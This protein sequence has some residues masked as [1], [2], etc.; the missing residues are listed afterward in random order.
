MKRALLALAALVVLAAAT[1]G[2]GLAWL[3]GTEAGLRWAIAAAEAR[4]EGRLRIAEPRGTLSQEVSFG[5]IAYADAGLEVLAE[6]VSGALSLTPLLRGRLGIEPLRIEALRISVQDRG[7]RGQAAP[8]SLPLGVR[9]ARVSVTRIELRAGA[10]RHVLEGLR[11]A[12]AALGPRALSASGEAS[13]RDERFPASVRFALDGTPDELTLALEGKADALPVT[14][15]LRARIASGGARG[16]VAL[17]NAQPGPLDAGKL[18]VVSARAGFSSPDLARATLEDLRV[19]LVGGGALAGAGE[20]S[21]RRARARVDASAVDL[22]ALYSTLRRTALAGT[23]DLEATADAQSVRGRLAQEGMSVRAKVTRRGDTIS[24]EDLY[25]EARGG[26]LAGTG[27]IGLGET[28]RAQARLRLGDFDPAAFGDYPQGSISGRFEL[29][30]R[31]DGAPTLDARWS[32]ERSRLDGRALAST[33]RARFSRERI[34]D[35]RIEASYGPARATVRGDFGRAGDRLDWRLALDELRAEG[36]LEGA[37]QAHDLRVSARV[38][39]LDVQA[40]LRGGLQGSTWQGEIRSLRNEGEYPLRLAA[41]ASLTAS[42]ERVALGRLEV[43]L[44]AGRLLVREAFWR[45]GELRSSGEFSAL[46]ARWL[47]LAAGLGERLRATMLVDGRSCTPR[48]S[49]ARCGSSAA[50]AIWRSCWG[51]SRCRWSSTRP[52]S[53]RA[54]SPR[55]SSSCSRPARATASSP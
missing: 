23:L 13:W 30:A 53:R 12:H 27:E 9:L 40:H 21:A 7:T 24:I 36:R 10:D 18:P 20:V 5:R 48:V 3:V 14:A 33:G 22:R 55:A 2:G 42:P 43:E 16:T 44:D 19:T 25:A 15:K 17:E 47:A 52:R 31:T 38:P 8:A 45:P 41:P 6:R 4:S 51:A 28:L 37:P 50:A 26:T 54:R 35:A 46:P 1:A 32:I 11:L 29:D 39:S 49:R 34:A